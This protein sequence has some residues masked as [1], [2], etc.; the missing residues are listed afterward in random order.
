MRNAARLL[1]EA[2]RPLLIVGSQAML[3]TDLTDALQLGV[4]GVGLPTYLIDR[5]VG[6][7]PPTRSVASTSRRQCGHAHALIDGNCV[8]ATAGC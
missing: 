7:L 1:R 3:E 8:N 6:L 2:Q 5:A 4:S